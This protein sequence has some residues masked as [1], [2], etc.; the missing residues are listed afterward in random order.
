MCFE[1]PN[2]LS[3]FDA[4]ASE[5]VYLLQFGFVHYHKELVILH[6]SLVLRCHQVIDYQHPT[7]FII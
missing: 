3:D 1:P 2:D 7:S 6:F 4:S 5:V